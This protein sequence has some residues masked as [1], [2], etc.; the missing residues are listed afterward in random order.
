MKARFFDVLD[1]FLS[2]NFHVMK[3]F[4]KR[5]EPDQSFGLYGLFLIIGA[6]H[7]TSFLIQVFALI[8]QII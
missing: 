3:A 4:N 2:F 7:Y 6:A 1:V 8:A 5:Q